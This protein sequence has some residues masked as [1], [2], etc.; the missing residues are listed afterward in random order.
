MVDLLHRLAPLGA[1]AEFG[2]SSPAVLLPWMLLVRGRK[3]IGREQEGGE[4][5]C[6]W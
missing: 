3:G 2:N 5:K 1:V 4:K 6:P